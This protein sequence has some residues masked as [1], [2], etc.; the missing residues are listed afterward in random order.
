[1]A[2]VEK[3]GLEDRSRLESILSCEVADME[4]KLFVKSV[5]SR[6]TARREESRMFQHPINPRDPP[7]A[8]PAYPRQKEIL[9][10]CPAT[11]YVSP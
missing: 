9:Q 10:L 8:R 2:I 11:T 3:G 6:K 4:V 1:M 5:P 7:L